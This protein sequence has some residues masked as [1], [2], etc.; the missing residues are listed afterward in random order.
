MSFSESL[1]NVEDHKYE[2]ILEMR[3]LACKGMAA[4]VVEEINAIDPDFFI[5]N[6]NLLFQLKQVQLLLFVLVGHICSQ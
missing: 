3:E 2:I 4:K 6:P 1:K 5:Q